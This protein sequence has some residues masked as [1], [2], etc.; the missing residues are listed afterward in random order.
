MSI[1]KA[2]SSLRRNLLM[3]AGAGNCM[4]LKD[5]TAHAFI[6]SGK[7]SFNV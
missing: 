3:V 1:M 6:E 5:S 7:A 2:V 4:Y